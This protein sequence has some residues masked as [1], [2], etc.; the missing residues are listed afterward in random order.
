[1]RSAYPGN[2]VRSGETAVNSRYGALKT[3][4]R[5]WERYNQEVFCD[6]QEDLLDGDM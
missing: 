6:N 1:M 2:G 3:S 5:G 4:P